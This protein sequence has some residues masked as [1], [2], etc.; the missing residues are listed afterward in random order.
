MS[1]SHT[2]H[3]SEHAHDDHG[4]HHVSSVRT[5]LGVL[6]TLLILTALTVYTAIYVDIGDTGNLILA[7]FIASFK[8]ILVCAFFMHLLHDKAF[9]S[10]ILFYCILTMLLFLGITAIDLGT[11]DRIDP[12]RARLIEEPPQTREAREAAIAEGKLVPDGN[13]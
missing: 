6:I 3:H 7:L 1:T 10:I 12:I 9:N 4:G 5:L 2:S 8:A 11:R 13:N